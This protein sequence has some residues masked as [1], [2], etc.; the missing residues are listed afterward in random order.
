MN[1]SYTIFEH[2]LANLTENRFNGYLQLVFWGY[3][4]II[5]YDTGKI[6]QAFSSDPELNLSG[7]TAV[8]RIIRKAR[9]KEGNIRVN[10]LGNELSLVLGIAVTAASS[11]DIRKMEGK[12][13][14]ETM[15]LMNREELT[16]YLDLEFAE[17]QGRGTIF[18]LD[19]NPMES[20]IQSSG[21]KIVSGE[22]VLRKF[23]TL[24]ENLHPLIT[25]HGVVHPGLIVENQAFIIPWKHRTE[26]EFWEKLFGYLES[27][28]NEKLLRE[29]FYQ[30][31]V[32]LM[33]V[34]GE[35]FPLL[36]PGSGDIEVSSSG[37]HLKR[38]VAR[39]RFK[40]AVTALLS[41]FW[42]NIPLRRRKKIKAEVI[43]RYAEK[44]AMSLDEGFPLEECQRMLNEALAGNGT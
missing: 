1:T 7:P 35:Q 6:I 37:F 5:V 3:E 11:T 36:H 8:Y 10:P 26:V 16:G 28:F 29:P 39:S 27:V 2:L 21:G 32:R 23:Q 25:V 24:A 19:G 40:E 34:L 4:G 18:F 17:R 33:T 20:V 41:A 44:L 38:L 30:T 43:L 12:S 9:Q 13:L 15:L 22:A 31:L 14:A 42:K